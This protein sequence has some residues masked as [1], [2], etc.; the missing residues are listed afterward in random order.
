MKGK[1]RKVKTVYDL[2]GRK[3]G[4]IASPGIYIADG[5]KVLVK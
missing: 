5:K 1:N 4:R 3:L 2:A